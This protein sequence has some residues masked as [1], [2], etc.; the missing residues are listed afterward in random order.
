MLGKASSLDEDYTLLKKEEADMIRFL[1]N[2]KAL[3]RASNAVCLI[4]VDEDLLS[5]QVF[6]NLFLT[7]DLVLKL[8]SFKDH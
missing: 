7:A 5:T 2:L 1:R 4:Q 8:T 6:N 3:I